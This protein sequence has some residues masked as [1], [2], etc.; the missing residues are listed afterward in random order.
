MGPLLSPTSPP[1]PVGISSPSITTPTTSG[2]ELSSPPFSITIR[3]ALPLSPPPTLL[4]STG[5]NGNGTTS[6]LST[7]TEVLFQEYR[8]LKAHVRDSSA[9]IIQARFRGYLVSSSC[10]S[11]LECIL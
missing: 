5:S 8:A 10:F 11:S 3:S 2:G 4:G 9:S 1:G 7:E 6:G